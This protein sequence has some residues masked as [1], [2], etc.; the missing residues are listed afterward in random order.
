MKRTGG[1]A[2]CARV[3]HRPAFPGRLDLS[4]MRQYDILVLH[5]R[6]ASEIS[7]LEFDRVLRTSGYDQ[8]RRSV[9]KYKLLVADASL[10]RPGLICSSR[11]CRISRLLLP[12]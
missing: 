8:I 9:N 7:A 3:R 4:M 10:M 2:V 11:V 12:A 6:K 1:E 5:D